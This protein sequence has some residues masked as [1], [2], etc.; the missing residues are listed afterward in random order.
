MA[1]AS[2]LSDGTRSA[3]TASRSRAAPIVSAASARSPVTITMRATPAVR[4]DWTAR[5]VSRL[6]SS[7][8]SKAPMVRPS[9]ATKTLSADRQAARRSARTAQSSGLLEPCTSWC[10]PA[11]TS[12][13]PIW[14]FDARAHGFAHIRWNF[15]PQALR[16]GRLDNGRRHDVLRCLLERR[17][18]PQHLV[19]ALARRR[20]DGDEAR[21]ADRKG[22]G[23]VEHHGV[24]ACQRFERPATL[25]EDAAPGSLR[26]A[27]DEGDRRGE[28]QRARG[29][30]NQHG[31][32]SDRVARDEPG[33]GCNDERDRQQEQRVAIG[34]AYERGF[35]G[36][37]R[38]DHAHDAG[39]G[40]LARSRG[41]PQLERLARV[42]RS[43][44]RKLCLAAIDGH[45]LAGQRRLVDHGGR[46]GDHPVDRDDLAGAHQDRIADGH[47]LDGHILDCGAR[48]AVCNSRRPVD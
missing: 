2:T 37:G 3:R 26:Y 29:S 8:S 11:L 30:R 15:E 22:A 45:G 44:A 41:G 1:T 23:L 17:R 31:Q 48:T 19:C 25:D 35:G 32:P 13:P 24:G 34:Q 16:H 47:L 40:A 9:T 43:A 10:E 42:Q 28:D 14:P 4:S 21:A 18:Q 6:S 39:I 20:L 27:G 36:L 5:G 7:P 38:R 12:R 33:T 46:T